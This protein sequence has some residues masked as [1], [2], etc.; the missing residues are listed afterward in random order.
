ML[1]VHYIITFIIATPYKLKQF[2][3]IPSALEQKTKEW[4]KKEA[5]MRRLPPKPKTD[6]PQPNKKDVS[7]YYNPESLR[8]HSQESLF[9]KYYAAKLKKLEQEKRKISGHRIHKEQYRVHVPCEKADLCR[10]AAV[11]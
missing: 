11:H 5:E 2:T 10:S 8:A 4:I 7:P 1:N 6:L 9:E 3:E